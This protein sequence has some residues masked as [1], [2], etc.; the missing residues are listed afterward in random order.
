M[1]FIFVDLIPIYKSKNHKLFLVYATMLVISYTI[2]V[3][4]SIDIKIPSPA[5][6]IK[7]AVISIFNL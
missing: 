4:I 2:R 5:N 3:L 7:K 6:P 1:F